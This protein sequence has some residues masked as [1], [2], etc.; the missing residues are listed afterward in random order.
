[1]LH[2]G[3]V[4]T[5]ASGCSEQE[6]N[7]IRVLGPVLPDVG[8]AGR[9]PCVQWVLLRVSCWSR[10]QAPLQ[11]QVFVIS[12][13]CQWRCQGTWVYGVR[14]LMEKEN[15]CQRGSRLLLSLTITVMFLHC[16][17]LI[18][19]SNLLLLRSGFWLVKQWKYILKT[20]LSHWLYPAWQYSHCSELLH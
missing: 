18:F 20:N 14:S 6:G 15:P 5:S 16:P 9:G 12:V 13:R 1:M 10:T 4:R 7:S 3:L 8:M 17:I 11:F 2:A 19:F